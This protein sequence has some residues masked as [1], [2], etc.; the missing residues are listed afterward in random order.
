MLEKNKVS[1][2]IPCYNGERLLR[3]SLDS[4]LAQTHRNLQV[5]FVNDGS[6][7]NSEQ[8]AK[9]Y[10]TAFADAGMEFKLYCK[11]NG[12]AASAVNVGLKHYDGDY[13]MW[14]DS[15]DMLLPQSIE[16][17]LLFFERNPQYDYCMGEGVVVTENK[18]D[19]ITAKLCRIPAANETK[20]IAMRDLICG[21]NTVYGPGTV[22]CK[23]ELMQTAIPPEGIYESREG[24]N[25]QL[26]IPITY[27]GTRGYIRETLFKCVAHE[28][29]HSRVKRT[30]SAEVEREKAFI[31]L[32]QRTVRSITQMP[33]EEKKQWNLLIEKHHL[34]KIFD[35]LLYDR[36]LTEASHV[37]SRL[38]QLDCTE[39]RY[40][41]VLAGAALLWTGK[42]VR[43]IRKLI[44]IKAV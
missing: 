18:Y 36:K 37:A 3:N 19:Q 43:K 32:C 6:T 30:R 16:K 1:I 21:K 15:D 33:E 14:L 24:Q 40:R 29:S 20:E 28:D 9:S 13:V 12:G 4:I 35:I 31:H 34:K 7:D 41:S 42:V 11:E 8:I 27:Y 26:M 25:W 17:V 23:K 5:I 10:E 22:M 44:E 39:F 2:I 38:R